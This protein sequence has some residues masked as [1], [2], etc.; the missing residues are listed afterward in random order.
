MSFEIIGTILGFALALS[1]ARAARGPTPQ[2]R[3]IALD[4]ASSIAVSIIV[5]LSFVYKNMMLIDIALTYAI[6]S[7]IGTLAVSKYFLRKR[8]WQQ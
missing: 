3:M 8:M 2:D 6:L 7:F 5:L 1:L 4:A